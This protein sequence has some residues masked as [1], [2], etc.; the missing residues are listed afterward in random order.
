MLRYV[1]HPGLVPPHGYRHAAVVGG[2]VVYTAGQTALSVSGTIEC[3]DDLIAQT[4]KWTGASGPNRIVC[5]RAL[6]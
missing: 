2:E 3:G 5:S 6:G 4:I 1:D